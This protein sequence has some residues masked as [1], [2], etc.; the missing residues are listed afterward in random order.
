MNKTKPTTHDRAI[1]AEVRCNKWL[2]D[3]NELAERGQKEKAQRYYDKAQFWLD[4]YN[5]LKGLN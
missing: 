2:A 3:A 5:K 4:R 1:D